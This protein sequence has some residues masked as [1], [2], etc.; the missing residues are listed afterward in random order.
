MVQLHFLKRTKV[1]KIVRSNSGEFLSE[2]VF[3]QVTAPSDDCIHHLSSY[4]A[5]HLAGYA[6]TLFFT[7]FINFL[8]YRFVEE[9]QWNGYKEKT[10]L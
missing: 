1:P 9:G 2:L 3:D 7:Y 6:L 8:Y 10:R 4:V 5:Q